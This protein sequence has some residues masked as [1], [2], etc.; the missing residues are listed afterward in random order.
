MISFILWVSIS[1]FLFP[2]IRQW[3]HYNFTPLFFSSRVHYAAFKAIYVTSV[4]RAEGFFFFFFKGMEAAWLYRCRFGPAVS[5]TIKWTDI[6]GPP[7]M[8][9]TL[10]I[11]RAL[12][13]LS[14][15]SDLHVCV[16]ISQNLLNHLPL[17]TF[18]VPR[19]WTITTLLILW[20]FI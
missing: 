4:S 13:G 16:D 8:N 15:Y 5:T 14:R 2:L 9:L 7:M 12:D 3:C 17:Q 20:L 11:L 1:V 19:G 6:H 18:I 10:V